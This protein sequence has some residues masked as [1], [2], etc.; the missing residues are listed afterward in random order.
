MA[1]DTQVKQAAGISRDDIKAIA[2]QMKAL[3]AARDA[4]LLTKRAA[5]ESLS[6]EIKSMRDKG[7]TIDQIAKWLRDNTPLAA[8]AATIR[9]ALARKRSRKP[10]SSTRTEAKMGNAGSAASSQLGKHTAGT[11][12]N[13]ADRPSNPAPPEKVPDRAKATDTEKTPGA[14]TFAIGSD[15]V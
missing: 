3:P 13:T 5:I 7:Y 9:S 15:D 6:G 12:R 10:A 2:A 8:S 14:G 11:V 1:D 4:A